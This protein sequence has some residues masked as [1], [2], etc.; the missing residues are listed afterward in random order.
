M[1]NVINQ[2]ESQISPPGQRT[3]KTLVGIARGCWLVTPNWITDSIR[4][5]KFLPEDKYFDI[6]QKQKVLKIEV[7]QTALN[8]CFVCL[9]FRY[10]IRKQDMPYS[11]KKIFIS[12]T[13]K[14]VNNQ[15]NDEHVFA[16]IQVFVLLLLSFNFRHLFTQFNLLSL[17]GSKC[18]SSPKCV[19]C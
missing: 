1:S 19:W 14:D 18:C 12:P 2:I 6:F 5:G 11:G 13:F 9:F 10:G 8:F 7:F 16:L 15:L 3:L 4:Q 17:I